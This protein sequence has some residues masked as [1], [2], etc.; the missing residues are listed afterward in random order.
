MAQIV[1]VASGSGPKRSN[2][3]FLHGLGGDL[4]RTWQHGPDDRSFW[5]RWL[6]EDV[7]GLA[8]YSIGYEAS[9][10]RWRGT[11]MHLA[12]R[13]ANVFARMLAEP[14]LQSGQLVLIG[15]SLGG[16]VIKQ[17]LQ[18]AESEGRHNAE[19]ASFLKRVDKVAFLATPHTGSD[20]AAFGNRIRIL[21]RP[22]AATACLV[23]N[24]PNLRALNTWYRTWAN[25]RGISHLTLTETD[26]IRILGMIVKPDNGDAGLAGSNPVPID[27]NHWTICKPVDRTYDT[28][29]F[30]RK[31]IES[32][33]ERPKTPTEEELA[34]LNSKV[35][36]LVSALNERGE[37]TSAEE[38]G[39]SP[40]AIIRLAQRINADIDD[41]DQALLELE[42]AVGVAAEVAEEGRRGSNI[43]D[44][45][46]TVLKRI[47]L[48][49]AA[50]QF[51]E[52]ATEADAAFA[53][54]NH[55][56]AER[57][58]A[59][60]AGGLKLLDAGLKQ[61]ILRRDPVS[62]ARRIERMVTLEHPDDRPTRFAAMRRRQDEWYQSGRHKVLNLDLQVSIEA[63]RLLLTCASGPDE[64]GAAL[65][66]LGLALEELG[67][68]EPDTARLNEAV[69]AY[70]A[71][72]QEYTRKRKPLL[73]A[74]T[75]NNLGN[76]LCT[77][78]ERER[79][80]ERLEEAVRAFREALQEFTRD[81][82]PLDW[83]MTKSNLGNALKI[84]GGRQNDTALLEQAVEAYRAALLEYARERLPLD[85]AMTQNNLGTALKIL[86]EDQ[87]DTVHL[88]DAI[89][90]FRA[91]LQEYTRE[92]LPLNWA[93]S[94]NN[95]G[96]ALKALGERQRNTAR[97]EE[98]VM[99]YRAA[100]EEY[101]RERVPL[102]WAMTQN[103]LGG[104][105]MAIGEIESG[106]AQLAEA[107]KAYKAALEEFSS[108][109]VPYFHDITKQNLAAAVAALEKR[110]NDTSS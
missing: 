71:A 15:H 18:N 69:E 110:K 105:L 70:R 83:A 64:T 107:I 9:V 67:R 60:I 37:T 34:A 29:V 102:D 4:R 98:A 1:H 44:F 81:R 48:K 47:A 5:P 101:T 85:W 46:D 54:W 28:Y 94:Q 50:G 87:S 90:A 61:D 3:I 76:A 36:R 93:G 43:G 108:E 26:A 97:L 80:T 8:V 58:E 109:R 33:A 30:V 7:P 49:S 17:L 6:A 99:A 100:L 25:A 103:N 23:R 52:A 79:G 53:Q 88:E 74:A 27:S 12:D 86:S 104:A 32:R 41:F 51:E 35:D 14:E 78:G 59:A 45:V 66:D 40:E 13:A 106:T 16:L 68:R 91:A 95:L 20:L 57:R 89:K 10:S 77:L 42:R 62:A 96:N 55:D 19:A 92:R 39:I 75:Q 84:L 2:V 56:E 72:L 11:A 73:W 38:A 31:F 24:D 65:A 63:A 22:S 21:A 82:V